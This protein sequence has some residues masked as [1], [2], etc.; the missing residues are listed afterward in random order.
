M[1]NRSIRAPTLRERG[2]LHLVFE[3][4]NSGLPLRLSK[5]LVGQWDKWDNV[6]PFVFNNEICDFVPNWD[7]MGQNGTGWDPDRPADSLDSD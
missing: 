1:L 6:K 7:K 3:I 4:R 2:I 5:K